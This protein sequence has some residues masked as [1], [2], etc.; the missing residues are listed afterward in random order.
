[1]TRTFGR[2]HMP[3][4]KDNRNVHFLLCKKCYVQESPDSTE[5]GGSSNRTAVRP[6]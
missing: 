2:I 1:M 4:K 5:Q 3:R 6:S